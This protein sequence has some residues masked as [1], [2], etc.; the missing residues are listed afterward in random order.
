MPFRMAA[1]SMKT[2]EGTRIIISADVYFYFF[3]ISG[4]NVVKCQGEHKPASVHMEV[5]TLPGVEPVFSC[6]SRH[7][8]S[9]PL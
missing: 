7:R 4:G 3:L 9:L 8:V 2:G 5:W 6:C 1:T